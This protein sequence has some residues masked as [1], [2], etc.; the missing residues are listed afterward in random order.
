MF[1]GVSSW[2]CYCGF[3][4]SSGR[5]VNYCLRHLSNLYQCNYVHLIKIKVSF[6]RNGMDFA[7]VAIP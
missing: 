6:N 2:N 7:V 5:D 1:S 3:R 4:T